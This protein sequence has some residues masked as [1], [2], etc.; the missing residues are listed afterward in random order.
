MHN[1][2]LNAVNI[3]LDTLVPAKFELVTRRKGWDNVMKSIEN[4][5]QQN[6]DSV[7]INCVVMKGFNEEE[8]VDFV[9]LTK[10]LPID[11][12]FIE[13]MPFDGNKW[14][15]KKMMTFKQM[16]SIIK[17]KYPEL[18]QLDPSLNETSKAYKVPNFSGQIG[19]ITSMTENFCGTCNR[20]RI[21][22][23][24]NLK[25]FRFSFISI[26]LLSKFI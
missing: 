8:I 24:G 22:A 9:S 1:L 2:G 6:F 19:F 18:K 7:K 14:N 25:V 17:E 15:V 13:Y 23:D 3:S 11:V 12:R 10:D 20:L 26:N 4:S 5:L 16:L 21:T